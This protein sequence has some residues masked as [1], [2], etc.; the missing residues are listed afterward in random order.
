MLHLLKIV[1]EV[2]VL[3][4]P[5]VLGQWLEAS[6]GMLPVE[7][8]SSNHF[9]MLWKFNFM[10]IIRLSHMEVNLATFSF[11]RY[12]QIYDSGVCRYFFTNALWSLM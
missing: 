8:F 3:G 10:E 5:H 12:H 4:L 1:V 2:K 6:R 11:W 9:C 7:G